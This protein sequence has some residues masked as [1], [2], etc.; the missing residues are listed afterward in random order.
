MN[1]CE[2]FN[3]YFWVGLSAFTGTLLLGIVA[4]RVFPKVGLMDRPH[5][6]GKTRE[7]IPYFGGLVIYLV[8]LI[9]VLAFVP[10]TKSLIGLLVGA[11]MVFGIG[12]L[13]DK[14]RLSP[15]LRLFVQALAGVVL[16][17]SGVGILS[18]NLPFVGV[19]DFTSPVLFG[20]MVASSLFTII[21]VMV[22]LN[23]VNFVDGISGLTSGIGF[24][25]GM[26]M[27]AVKG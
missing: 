1:L 5:L 10:M 25:A 27:G 14:F 2:L 23:T 6:Y 3:Q 16:V 26:T 22:I 13:D 20:V 21:W 4:L 15:F 19:L 9:A 7:P 24:I 11:S 18:I 12:F 17:I 8:F